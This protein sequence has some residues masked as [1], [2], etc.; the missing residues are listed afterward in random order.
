MAD[1]DPVDDY[2]ITPDNWAHTLPLSSLFP[3]ESATSHPLAVD[4]GCGKGRY[5]LAV[6]RKHPETNFLGIDRMTSRMHKV[7]R[8]LAREQLTNVRLLQVEAAYAIRYLLP[9]ASVT[10][11]SIFFP[12]PWPKRRHH[13]RRLFCPPLLNDIYR[14][15]KPNGQLHIATDDQEYFTS[16][17]ALFNHDPRFVPIPS[18]EPPEDE[19]TD[20]ERIFRGQGKPIGRASFTKAEDAS[21]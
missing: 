12:D 5:L 6:A 10:T 17:E 19:Q 21:S 7:S 13:R 8:K 4:V 9:E 3:T 14:T 2:I 1:M 15:L 16:I 18:Y 20:F 11:Y